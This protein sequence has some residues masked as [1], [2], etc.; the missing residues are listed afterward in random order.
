MRL[1]LPTFLLFAVCYLIFVSPSYAQDNNLTPQGGAEDF[2]NKLLE[3][4]LDN[5]NKAALP[6]EAG[7]N[8]IS[9]KKDDKQSLT[10]DILKRISGYTV[11]NGFSLPWDMHQVSLDLPSFFSNLFKNGIVLPN[12]GNQVAREWAAEYIP[13]VGNVFNTIGNKKISAGQD[14]LAGNTLN[15]TNVLGTADNQNQPNNG[16]DVSLPLVEC[17]NLPYTI[18]LD[19]CYK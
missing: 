16:M 10:E 2:L 19:R 6:F 13:D 18:S 17:A 12:F 14:S 4:R 8:I 11:T 9:G 3:N 1:F 15:S 5:I 7:E